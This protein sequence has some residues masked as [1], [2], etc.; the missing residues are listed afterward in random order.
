VAELTLTR[1]E[2]QQLAMLAYEAWCK[3]L[4]QE[5]RPWP[6][7]PVDVQDAW[8]SAAERVA[9]VVSDS[10]TATFNHW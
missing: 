10:V 5:P 3:A 8:C 1:G 6:A 9:E 2:I 7:L 4:L